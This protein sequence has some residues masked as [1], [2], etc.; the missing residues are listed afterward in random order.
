VLGDLCLVSPVPKVL[1]EECKAGGGNVRH[2]NYIG[3]NLH[4]TSRGRSACRK[5]V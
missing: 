3:L 4:S 2:D 1:F 5:V